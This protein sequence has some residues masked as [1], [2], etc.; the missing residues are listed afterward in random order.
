MS[1]PINFAN[2]AKSF[3]HAFKSDAE[4]LACTIATGNP[5]GVVTMSILL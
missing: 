5:V 1:Q 3:D 4:L 2:C